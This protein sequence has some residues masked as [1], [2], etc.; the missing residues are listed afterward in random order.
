MASSS[1][2][3]PP[4][5]AERAAEIVDKLPSHP[6]EFDHQDRY[7]HPW[8]RPPPDSHRQGASASFPSRQLPLPSLFPITCMRLSLGGEILLITPFFLLVAL[9]RE[10]LENLETES[11]LIEICHT[12]RPFACHTPHCSHQRRARWCACRTYARSG[13]PH[14]QSGPPSEG[15]RSHQATL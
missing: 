7:G 12:H 4:P 5:P 11:M 6:P 13:G 3:N 15:C 14:R 1:S 2:S 10:N 8:Q 9:F